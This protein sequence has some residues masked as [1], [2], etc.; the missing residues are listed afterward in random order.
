MNK[1]LGIILRRSIL[2]NTPLLYCGHYQPQLYYHINRDA[3]INSFC[4]QNDCNLSLIKRFKHKKKGSVKKEQMDDLESD[5][6]DEEF[7]V[8]ES[9]SKSTIIT[10]KV[11]SL[12]VDVVAKAGLGVSRKKIEE[13]FYDSRIRVNGE[14]VFKLSAEVKVDDEI[15]LIR[16]RSNENTN[17]LIVSRITVLSIEP[18]S[19]GI[20]L[21]LSK[22]KSLLI[23]EYSVPWKN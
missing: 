12:R 11:N 6:E 21:K 5:E 19:E 22:D 1:I 4:V 17:L 14:K 7:E 18:I 16:G 23:E 20:R 10:T 9:K 8:D 3:P 15:D 2:Q 13:A